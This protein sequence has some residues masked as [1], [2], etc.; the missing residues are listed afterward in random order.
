MDQLYEHLHY[1]ITPDGVTISVTGG[2]ELK[3]SWFPY[4]KLYHSPDAGI[5]PLEQATVEL[6]TFLQENDYI[7]TNLNTKKQAEV[8]TFVNSLAEKYGQKELGFGKTIPLTL[9]PTLKH[10]DLAVEATSKHA[11]S[12]QIIHRPPLSE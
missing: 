6:L 1:E 5:S 2:Y 7:E 4:S 10:F 11:K 8:L 12:D 9:K 3:R